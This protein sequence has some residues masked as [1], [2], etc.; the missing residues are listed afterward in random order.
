MNVLLTG[1]TGYIGFNLCVRLL[2]E[3]NNVTCLVRKSS[4]FIKLERLKSKNLNIYIHKDIKALERRLA[5]DKVDIVVHVASKVLNNHTSDDV[6]DLVNSNILLGT[7]MLEA[8]KLAGVRNFINTSTFWQHYNVDDYNPVNLYA[9]T[10]EGF[11]KIMQYYSDAESI[12]CI[13]LELYDTYGPKDKRPKLINLILNS[14]I[15][16]KL[17]LTKGEQEVELVYIDDVIDAYLVAMNMLCSK[18]HGGVFVKYAVK[19]GIRKNLKEIVD[20]I[21]ETF[22][23]RVEIIW[24]GIPYRDREVMKISNKYEKL[25]NWEPKVNLNEGIFRILNSKK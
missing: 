15:T 13:N 25:P 21:I 6:V 8:M 20:Q 14:D 17:D 2:Q 10:K 3:G 16:I 11:E 5:H 12:N 7:E 18:S 19:G 4:N 9:A 23:S 24:G 1:S 22:D